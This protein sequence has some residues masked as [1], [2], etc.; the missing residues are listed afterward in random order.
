MADHAIT[1][2]DGATVGEITHASAAT[3]TQARIGTAAN[4]AT[5]AVAR[6]VSE[7]S[8]VKAVS[9]VK[10]PEP[11]AETVAAEAVATEVARV[12]VRPSV[13]AIVMDR[14]ARVATSRARDLT[15]VRVAIRTAG[16]I[17]GD[18]SIKARDPNRRLGA[19]RSRTQLPGLTRT[20]ALIKRGDS[21][22]GR[23][24]TK[25]ALIKVDDSNRGLATNRAGAL[26]KTVGRTKALCATT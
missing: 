18:A 12:T 10:V 24:A 1:D 7:G 22:P 16:P 15:R 11:R 23:A 6:V 2:S 14:V 19:I 26:I 20:A 13:A 5:A 8:A 9:V 17:R 4:A 3:R 25:A 21:T